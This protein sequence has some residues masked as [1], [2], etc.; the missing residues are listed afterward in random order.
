[1]LSHQRI[2]VSD[3]ATSLWIVFII[4][5]LFQSEICEFSLVFFDIQYVR[6]GI[7]ILKTVGIYFKQFLKPL[8]TDI[9]L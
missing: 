8:K 4:I 5:K 6:V 2:I 9:E 3:N 1:M 7:H